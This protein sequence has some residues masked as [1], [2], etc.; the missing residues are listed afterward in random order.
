MCKSKSTKPC[1]SLAQG[2][3]PISGSATLLAGAPVLESRITVKPEL[4][5]VIALNMTYRH[6]RAEAIEEVLAEMRSRNG[7]S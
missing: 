3:Q 7:L 4:F 2:F 6:E 5:S 1:C